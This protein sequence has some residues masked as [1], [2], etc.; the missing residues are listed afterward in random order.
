MSALLLAV[1]TVALPVRLI[2]NIACQYQKKLATRV[3]ATN[4]PPHLRRSLAKH[5]FKYFIPKG[6]INAHGEACHRTMN[7]NHERQ[8]G[9]SHGETVEQE[10]AHINKCATA[11]R[12]M[13]PGAQHVILEDQW[14]GWNWR[15]TV[16]LGTLLFLSKAIIF[17]TKSRHMVCVV[18]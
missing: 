8:V 14:S 7:L 18:T 9:R 5:D 13:G 17:N 3:A 15:R 10:W 1:G 4:F 12:E 2:Y 16:A 6:H 11:T